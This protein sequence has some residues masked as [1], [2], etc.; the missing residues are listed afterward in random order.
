VTGRWFRAVGYGLTPAGLIDYE[1]VQR[2]ARQHRPKMIICGATAY[3]RTIDFS[4]FRAIADDVGALLLADISHVA[5]L[6]AAGLHPN[7]VDHAHVTTTC[8]H[9]QL[10]GPRGALILLGRDADRSTPD[11]RRTL[12]DA[13]ARAVFPFFQG[14]PAVNAIAAKARALRWCA[15]AEFTATARRIR[16]NASALAD[17]FAR[18]GY[19]L[20]SGGTD[21]HI[22]LLDL[23]DRPLTGLV[24]QRALESARIIV[25]KNHVPGDRRPATVTSGLRLGT[26]TLAARGAAATDMD[27]CA[28]LVDRVLRATSPVGDG[29][30]RL[31]PVVRDEVTAEVTR[32]CHGW[33]IPHY[34]MT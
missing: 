24:A 13:V 23:G 30:F 28:A 33:P 27:T 16:D 20:V 18:R 7:P 25:N 10:F 2:L 29:G 1:Q 9:K 4:R 15:S 6:V 31:D 32:L 14:A 8:T 26:N 19:R 22:V 12:R 34:P 17:A 11:G 3:P 5:G 21:N